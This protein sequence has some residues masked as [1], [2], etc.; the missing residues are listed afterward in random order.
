[1]TEER[2]T[3]RTDGTTSERVVERGP[4]AAP[5][6]TTYVEKRGGAT[7]IIVAIAAIAL[8]AIAAWFFLNMSQQQNDRT[9]AVAGAAESVADSAGNA[10]ESVGNAAERA[11]DSVAR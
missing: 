9:E 7:G 3:E 5:S 11:A 10:A 8:I 1:M 4:A 6:S 2:V